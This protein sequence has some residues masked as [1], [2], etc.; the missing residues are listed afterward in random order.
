MKREIAGCL[1]DGFPRCSHE[2]YGHGIGWVDRDDGDGASPVLGR[3]GTFRRR[4]DYDIYFALNQL[5]Y[6]LPQSLGLELGESGREDE[7]LTFDPTMLLQALVERG[8]GRPRDR[9]AE[10]E[11][12]DVVYLPRRLRSGSERRGEEATRDQRHESAPN[13]YWITSSARCSS[14]GGSVRPSA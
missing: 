14:D 4:H 5:G 2:S 8:S 7:I 10:P 9:G 3:E 11:V 12:P 1:R 13:H 6:Q